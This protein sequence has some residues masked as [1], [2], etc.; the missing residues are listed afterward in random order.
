MPASDER[1]AAKAIAGS[2]V[3][4]PSLRRNSITVGVI[5][6]TIESATTESPNRL[7]LVMAH[8]RC[9][10]PQVARRNPRSHGCRP[11]RHHPVARPKIRQT[12][13]AARPPAGGG[14]R[15]PSYPRNPRPSASPSGCPSANRSRAVREWHLSSR[16]Q[17]VAHPRRL[18]A[19]RALPSVAGQ[20]A[21]RPGCSPRTQS[22]A[23]VTD[24]RFSAPTDRPPAAA[25]V[26]VGEL[27]FRASV[28]SRLARL[29]SVGSVWC[30]QSGD[31]V[32][33]GESS[34]RAVGGCGRVEL[35]V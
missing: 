24:H 5:T 19:V 33:D 7:Q 34:C 15:A 12:A 11:D 18:A 25:V 14:T 16:A 4:G 32:D 22:G 6:R 28:V 10:R 23:L 9:D 29:R 8:L 21:S 30:D 17:S 35:W 1:L 3:G 31:G 2:P 20:A 26:L 13:S 27:P